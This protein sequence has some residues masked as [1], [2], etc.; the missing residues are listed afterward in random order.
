[1]N[2]I[3]SLFGIQYPIVQAGMIWASGWRLASAVS[4][5]G[6]LG[7]IG[8]GSMYPDVLK[9]HIQR[10]KEAT[11]KP[12]GVNVPLLYPDIEQLINIILEEKVQ[13]VFT[14]AGN[15]KTWTP[16]L[17]AAGVKVVH[18][19][20]SSAFALKSEAAGVDAVVAEGF[21]AGGH[22]GREETT[23]MVLIPAVCEKVQIPVIA[24]GGIGSGRAMAAAFALGASGVQVGSRF[25]ATPEASS[26]INFKEA[27]VNA[28]EGDTMLSLKKLTPV[29]LIK[30]H[31][32]ETVKTAEDGGADP[33]ALKVLLG[34]ARAKTGMFEG[35][36]EEGELEI[37]QVSALIHDIKPAAA[38]VE[39]IWNEF[40]VVRRQLAGDI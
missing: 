3:S 15:P 25:V 23:T 12:F 13:V 14:S 4:N 37:G 21:E 17:K 39:D 26:H 24:A 8:A 28:K 19:V 18:V 27:V 29:R 20:S 40:Q 10:C 9:H 6:G 2:R 38:I 30:N 34:R 36:L 7:L 33:D 32:Y 35:N 22:N 5:A 1:M 11:N 16:V 31:F